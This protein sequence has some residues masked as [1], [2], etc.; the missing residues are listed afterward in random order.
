MTILV[1]DSTPLSHF[2]RAGALP[3]LE[4]ITSAFRRI[5]PA[6]VMQEIMRGIP[7]FP[8]LAPVTNLPWLEIVELTE[9]DEIIAFA[10]YKAMLG[11]GIERNNGE[12]AVL[13]WTGLHG[14]TAI[15]SIQVPLAG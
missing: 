14:G 15:V 6:E 1:L 12:A 4:D 3:V 10:R 7:R 9:I 11:G 2:A 8:A 5:V 13:A